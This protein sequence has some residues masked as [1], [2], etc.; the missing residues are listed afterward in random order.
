MIADLVLLYCGILNLN[1]VKNF[2][3]IDTLFMLAGVLPLATAMQKTGAGT[4][5]ADFILSPS[6]GNP[7]PIT[8]LIAFYVAGAVLTS[9]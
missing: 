9:L 6:G 5:L 3:N 1:D 4:V 7:A 2:M 8:V